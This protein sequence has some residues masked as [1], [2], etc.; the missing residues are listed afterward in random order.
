[1]LRICRSFST[2]NAQG[3]K[4]IWLYKHIHGLLYHIM[5]WYSDFHQEAMM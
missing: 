2:V 5:Q 3:I 1:M 4:Q